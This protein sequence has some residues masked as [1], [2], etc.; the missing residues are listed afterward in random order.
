MFCGCTIDAN[1]EMLT[2]NRDIA[3][4][5]CAKITSCKV[6][7]NVHLASCVTEHRLETPLLRGAARGVGLVAAES[8]WPFE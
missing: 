2:Q 8:T 6:E 5:E 4:F 7:T 1:F 3:D